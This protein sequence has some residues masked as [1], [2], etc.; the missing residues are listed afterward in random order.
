VVKANSAC[1]GPNRPRDTIKATEPQNTRFLAEVLPEL[2]GNSLPESAPSRG[3][4]G[5]QGTSGEC[6]CL[7]RVNQEQKTN[8]FTLNKT[9]G[10]VV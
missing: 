10:F 5:S 4:S 8:N 1:A 7:R 6:D 2:G 9:I 3:V